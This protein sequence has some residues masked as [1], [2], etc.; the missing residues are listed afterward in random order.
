MPMAT[1]SSP[2]PSPRVKPFPTEHTSQHATLLT[3]CGMRHTI[4]PTLWPGRLRQPSTRLQRPGMWSAAPTTP[5]IVSNQ[6]RTAKPL[7]S[8]RQTIHRTMKVATTLLRSQAQLPPPTTAP[9]S[10]LLRS[11]AITASRR[12]VAEVAAAQVEVQAA[13]SRPTAL[14]SS[15]EAPRPRSSRR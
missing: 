12:A 8:P 6:E 13:T 11:L 5:A 3:E 4:Q 1:L 10:P 14:E 7:P 15:L 2:P 9:K